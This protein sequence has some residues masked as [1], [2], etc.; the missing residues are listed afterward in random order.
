MRLQGFGLHG[1]SPDRDSIQ[2]CVRSSGDTFC[3]QQVLFLLGRKR[4]KQVNGGCIQEAFE[5]VS[6]K[7]FFSLKFPPSS[8]SASTMLFASRG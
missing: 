6:E 5:T 4:K 2:V 7:V 3:S 8:F 1:L